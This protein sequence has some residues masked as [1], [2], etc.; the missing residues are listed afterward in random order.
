MISS[1]A[2]ELYEDPNHLAMKAAINYCIDMEYSFM[3]SYGNYTEQALQKKEELM[4]IA[5]SEPHQLENDYCIPHFKGSR[6]WVFKF[7]KKHKLVFRKTHYK[8]RGA[9]EEHSVNA[10][11]D[12]LTEAIER[13]GY[14][15]ILNLDETHV[16]LNNFPDKTIAHC[17]QDTVVIETD[18]L[19]QKAGTTYIGTI[20][21]NPEKK[22]PLYC[23]ALGRSPV[24]ERKYGNIDENK[25]KMD[26]YS[27]GWCSVEVMKRYLAWLSNIMR[28]QPF[29]LVLDVYTTHIDNDVKQRVRE[30]DIELIYVPVN[31]TGLYQP[32]D[33]KIF[34]VVK[35]KN[36]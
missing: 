15:R 10:Y 22:F 1:R 23:I 4:K 27:S 34:G 19:D 5:I 11:I 31:G 16:L 25:C 35:K 36:L 17:G 9:V 7:M 8:R 30:L 26:H 2:K 33:R 28:N 29:A 14:D 12:H 24:C 32:L 18:K 21:M 6:N 20:S 3:D 13:Y